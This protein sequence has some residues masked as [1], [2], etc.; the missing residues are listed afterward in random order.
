MTMPVMMYTLVLSYPQPVG[1]VFS[2]LLSLP[3]LIFLL[4]AQRYLR[5]G[6]LAAGYS[7]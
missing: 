1:A 2:V 6:Y 4:L 5:A 7:L 3:S